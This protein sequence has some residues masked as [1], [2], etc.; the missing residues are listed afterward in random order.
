MAGALW[1]VNISQCQ[2]D[3]HEFSFVLNVH[4]SKSLAKLERL[5]RCSPILSALFL[6][7]LQSFYCLRIHC[8]TGHGFLWLSLHFQMVVTR[9][10]IRKAFVCF[11]CVALAVFA[12]I[13]FRFFLFLYYCQTRLIILEAE[14]APAM[15]LMAQWW[16]LLQ[17][18][19]NIEG[20]RTDERGGWKRASQ[21]MK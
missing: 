14:E 21:H 2:H 6:Q 16:K 19:K 11:L 9:F 5:H 4:Y 17:Q 15:W 10:S 20:N 18:P 1:A 8:V 12:L 13:F 7:V 3:S